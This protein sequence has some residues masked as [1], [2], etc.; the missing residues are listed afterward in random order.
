MANGNGASPLRSAGRRTAVLHQLGDQP[1]GP[2]RTG[3]V[4]GQVARFAADQLQDRGSERLRGGVV[5]V[6]PIGG[7]VAVEAV[8]HV[9][10]L[11]E[12]A[13]E[14]QRDERPARGN[15]LHRGREPTLNQSHVA[16]GQ[17]APELVDVTDDLETGS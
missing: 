9:E 17:V 16:N 3:A 10:A 5:E 4:D 8:A 14:R 7:A 15:Q 12:V 13:F 1:G 6:E 11:L 2:A